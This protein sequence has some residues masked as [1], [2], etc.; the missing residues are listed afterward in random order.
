MDFIVNLASGFMNSFTL[1]G[2]QFVAWVT[3]IIPTVLMLLLLMNAIIA[4]AGQESVDKLARICTKNPLLRY[5]VLPFV[6][7][8]MLGCPMGLSM[9]KFMPE[10]YKPCYFASA[11]RHMH[12]NLGLF[13][14]INAGELFVWL[15]IANGITTLGL[16]TMPLAIRFLLVSLFTNFIDGWLTEFTT[17]FVEKQQGITLSRTM[18]A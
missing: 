11:S 15:G 18:K 2:Q 8:F 1:G 14:H 12:S 10:F 7:D 6:S 9:G 13:P 17:K 4:L 5:L 16:N 3:G